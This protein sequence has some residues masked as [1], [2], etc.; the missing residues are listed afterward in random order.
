MKISLNLTNFC[1]IG[2]KIAK[3]QNMHK[4]K[5]NNGEV[6]FLF[7]SVDGRV[8]LSFAENTDQVV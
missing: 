3:R 5:E 4:T 1:S 8:L 6:F 2:P 7:G